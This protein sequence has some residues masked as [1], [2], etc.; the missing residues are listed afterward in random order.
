[1]EKIDNAIVP[2]FITTPS[3]S[4]EPKENLSILA[5]GD[6]HYKESNIQDMEEFNVKI[7]QFVTNKKPDIVV[8]LGDVLHTHSDINVYPLELATTM[9][10]SLSNLVPVYVLIGNHDRPNNSD[11]MSKYH[12]F[13]G[14]QFKQ[15]ITVISQTNEAT[16][17]GHRLVFVPYVFPGRLDEA[18]SYIFNP[19]INVT[20]YFTHQEFRGAKMGAIT[21]EIGDI[22]PEERSLVIS[23]HIHDYDRLQSN[24]IYTGTPLMHGFG[25]T[26]E[27][28]I[29]WFEFDS[30]G[31]WNEFRH[32]LNITP[33]VTINITSDQFHSWIPPY[34]KHIRLNIK[35][36]TAEIT[37]IINSSRFAELKL[38]GIKLIPKPIDVSVITP[39]MSLLTN[40]NNSNYQVIEQNF[41]SDFK[42]YIQKLHDLLINEPE[43]LELYKEKL[44]EFFQTSGTSGNNI[45]FNFNS[46]LENNNSNSNPPSISFPVNPSVSSPVNLPISFPTNLPVS[47]PVN[48]PISFPTNPPISFPSNPPISFPVNPPVISF[49]VNSNPPSF[50]IIFN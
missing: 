17:K 49:P 28:T 5:I 14:L 37:G 3:I 46:P 13:P 39:V 36:T 32:D 34:G 31:G 11:F 33:K 2:N 25:D 40:E 7:L 27:K 15:N 22:W 23:G 29:S 47:F 8:I 43:L 42:S 30:Q 4:I 24:I 6:P 48:S 26:S 41:F 44:S 16:I 20:T 38:I 9:I 12:P 19:Y 45:T 10:L 35:G 1:M 50:P 18:L 21:S